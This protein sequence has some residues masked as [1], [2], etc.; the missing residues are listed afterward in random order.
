MSYTLATAASEAKVSKPTVFRWI[1]SGKLSASKTEDGTYRIDPAE[2]HRYL[3]STRETLTPDVTQRYEIRTDAPSDTLPEAI[4]LRYEVEKL[5]SLLETERQ[6][7]EAER[8]R[9]EEW[10]TQADRWA[11]QAE[12]LA[13]PNP[14]TKRN[15][16]WWP[17]R[18]AG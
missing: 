3:D 12:R 14:E 17:F 13:L 11:L 18:R 2:L 9:A 10:K 16:P 1:K 8:Q 15:T 4:A 7:V 6:R 5:K